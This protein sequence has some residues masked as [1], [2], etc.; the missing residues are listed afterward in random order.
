MSGTGTWGNATVI[1]LN[2]TGNATERDDHFQGDF[3]ASV[4]IGGLLLLTLGPPSDNNVDGLAGDD[5]IEGNGGNDT[6]FGSAGN[7]RLD[8]DE[9][10][11]SLHGGLDQDT[12]NGGM[13]DDTL[14][15]GAGRDILNGGA[16]QDSMEGSGG[17][18]VYLVNRIGDIV[19]ESDSE[20]FDLVRSRAVAWTLGDHV[21]ALALNG[22]A[23]VGNGNGLAN[24]IVGSTGANLLSGEGGNDRLFGGLG[25]DTL[26]GGTGLD[27]MVGGGGGDTFRF[28]QPGD[29]RDLIAD[30]DGTV[31]V[32][33]ISATGFSGLSAGALAADRLAANA[34]GHADAA[35]AQIC[36]DTDTGRLWWDTNG[37]DP[38]GRMLIAVLDGA[39]TLD[40]GD[41]TVIA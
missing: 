39:P 23:V 8:G 11:D 7:D 4:G 40:A 12:L 32:I 28:V 14:I 27:H 34:G 21:E 19:V 3:I 35:F 2:L 22:G 41:I 9:G 13:G 29:G 25:A 16:G 1:P 5:T 37:T 15:G 30:F 10:D 24:R 33:E 31:D 26:Q 20:G 38:G 36:Y 6:L 18:D 17:N